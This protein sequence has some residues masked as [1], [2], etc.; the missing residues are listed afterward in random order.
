VAIHYITSDA[1]ATVSQVAY[2]AS[3]SS[4]SPCCLMCACTYAVGGDTVLVS[5]GV[6]IGEVANDRW[7]PTFPIMNDGSAGNL[8]VFKAE[9]PAAIYYQSKVRNTQRRVFCRNHSSRYGNIRVR[10][11]GEIR[12][13]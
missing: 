1:P 3:T 8:I 4:A 11:R 12:R 7:A 2:D 5:S 10:R 13:H 6:Y 9:Y